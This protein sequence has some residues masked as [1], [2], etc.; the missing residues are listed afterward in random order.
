MDFHAC[1]VVNRRF[2]MFFWKKISTSWT[3]FRG[4]WNR[5]RSH[6]GKIQI[7]TLFK[8]SINTKLIYP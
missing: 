8:A 1:H 2:R 7:E 4:I 5:N 6:N 3:F